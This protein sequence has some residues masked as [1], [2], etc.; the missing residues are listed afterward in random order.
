MLNNYLLCALLKQQLEIETQ[1]FVE[2]LNV[3]K[4]VLKVLIFF[5]MLITI[6]SP[7]VVES[8]N[9][10]CFKM[11]CVSQNIFYNE[12]SVPSGSVAALGF[13]VHQENIVKRPLKI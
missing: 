2:K 11:N 7:I 1:R 3:L 10:S 12:N 8:Y 9:F 6:F 13:P 4:F 5:I